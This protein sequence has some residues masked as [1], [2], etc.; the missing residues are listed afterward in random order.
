MSRKYIVKLCFCKWCKL[1]GTLNMVNIHYCGIVKITFINYYYPYKKACD[2]S[3]G[4]CQRTMILPSDTITVPWYMCDFGHFEINQS[5]VSRT[6]AGWYHKPKVVNSRIGSVF[7]KRAERAW[8]GDRRLCT[9]DIS[10]NTH[11]MRWVRYWPFRGTPW[12]SGTTHLCCAL[13]QSV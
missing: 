11:Q 13:F 12:G 1:H 5:L 8:R 4:I 2:A 10:L 7:D 6:H 9:H 3:D